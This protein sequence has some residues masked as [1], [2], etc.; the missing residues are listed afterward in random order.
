MKS[1]ELGQ[2]IS[3]EITNISSHGVWILFQGKEYFAPY[4][5]F[6]WF[7]KASVNEILNIETTSTGHF[8]WPELD[9]DLHVEILKNPEKFNLISKGS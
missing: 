3:A 7:K 2:N 5:T 4:E 8:H 6:P 1:E 9:V